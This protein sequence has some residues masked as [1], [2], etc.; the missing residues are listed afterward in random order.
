MHFATFL[1]IGCYKQP[2]KPAGLEIE[3]ANIRRTEN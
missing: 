2:L 3:I 1:P